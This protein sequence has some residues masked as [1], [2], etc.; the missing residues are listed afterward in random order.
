MRSP[1]HSRLVV[2]GFLLLLLPA[3]RQMPDTSHLP[4]VQRIWCTPEHPTPGQRVTFH[5]R[6]INRGTEPIPGGTQF[7]IAYALDGAVLGAVNCTAPDII[8]TGQY[9]VASTGYSDS[10]N[11]EWNAT[12]GRHFVVAAIA[13]W[14]TQ[15]DNADV[16][17]ATRNESLIVVGP[18]AT[19]NVIRIMPLG[20][21]V[22]GGSKSTTSYRYFLSRSLR[23]DGYS[24][25]SFVGSLNGV[26][27]GNEPPDP[28]WESRHEG[29]PGWTAADIVNGSDEHR[30]WMRGKLSGSGGWGRVYRPDIALVD[31]G[32]NDLS[33]GFG[34]KL[35][36]SNVAKVIDALRSANPHIA[37]ALAEVT[38][39]WNN[40]PGYDQIPQLNDLLRLLALRKTTYQSPITIVDLFD[41]MDVNVD[42]IDGV[43]PTDAGHQKIAEAWLPVVESLIMR[44]RSK[45]ADVDTD[46][47]QPE[48]I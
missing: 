45:R 36:A 9:D 22:T 42:L 23:K 43:H 2:L 30:D 16:V 8:P 15:F 48:S 37:I 7:R 20:D 10:S 25:V 34:P 31:L 35:A 13:A 11:V 39:E 46:T 38:P 6:I 19:S 21:S 24:D 32:L 4:T 1:S 44:A 40:E 3:C 29:H 14:S 47:D 5:V 17:P 33:R 28:V 27:D 12:P 41:G 26:T 18:Q